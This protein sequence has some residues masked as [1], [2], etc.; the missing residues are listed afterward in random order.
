VLSILAGGSEGFEGVSSV[1]LL[2]S[3]DTA[4]QLAYARTF[5]DLAVT[6]NAAEDTV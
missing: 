1:V 2:V 4:E 5:A 6:V 3:P